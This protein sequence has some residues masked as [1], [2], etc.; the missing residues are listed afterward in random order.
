M[1]AAADETASAADAGGS[2]SFAFA[3]GVTASP[4]TANPPTAATAAM[5]FRL[6]MESLL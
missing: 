5:L 6:R 4:A 3:N 2:G 1:T